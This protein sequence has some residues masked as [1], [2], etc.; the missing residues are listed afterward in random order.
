MV[1]FNSI[2]MHQLNE[3]ICRAV[4]ESGFYESSHNTRKS[5]VARSSSESLETAIGRDKSYKISSENSLHKQLIL[6]LILLI[7]II[8]ILAVLSLGL[9]LVIDKILGVFTIDNSK[10]EHIDLTLLGVKSIR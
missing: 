5:T 7:I 2:S 4:N 3:R 9:T 8:M 6:D 10:L 1:F